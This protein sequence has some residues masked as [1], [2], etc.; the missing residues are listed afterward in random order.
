MLIHRICRLWDQMIRVCA[1]NGHVN[2]T[3]KLYNQSKK[4]GLKPTR[5]TLFWLLQVRCI[6]TY[7]TIL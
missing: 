7:S 1:E 4:I 6:L 5:G 2:K 3:F